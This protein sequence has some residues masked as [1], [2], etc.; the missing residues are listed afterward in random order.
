[1]DEET[2]ALL[3]SSVTSYYNYYLDDDALPMNNSLM[4]Y[5][6]DDFIL[7][8]FDEWTPEYA[9]EADEEPSSDLID[10][11]FFNVSIAESTAQEAND[12]PLPEVEET[13]S[14]IKSTFVIRWLGSAFENILM[15]IIQRNAQILPQDLKIQALPRSN[16]M[17]ALLRRGRFETDALIEVGDRL[18]FP[19]LSMSGGKL[20]IKRLTLQLWGFLG[21]QPQAQDN[22]SKRG[23]TSTRFPKQF[24]LEVHDWTFT[25]QDLLDSPCIRNGFRRLLV[26]IL[27]DKG[28]Q[29]SSIRV[30]SLDILV[31]NVVNSESFAC[32]HAYF[33][34]SSF[35]TTADRKDRCERKSEDDV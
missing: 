13:S 23:G 14:T 27:R 33:S 34:P 17:S 20:E 8:N 19:A 10:A 12:T 4:Y 3:E 29:S 32:V 16:A 5:R 15:G 26:R 6:P 11:E 2:E 21:Q 24:D 30:N 9:F 25:R 28:V 1:M 22:N 35:R 7:R 18:A 31:R